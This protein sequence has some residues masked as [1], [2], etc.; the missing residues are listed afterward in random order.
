MGT[1]RAIGR[2]L[3][4]T[5]TSAPRSTERRCSDSRSF[6]AEILTRIMAKIR[7]YLTIF[8]KFGRLHRVLPSPPCDW[9]GR[10]VFQ[11]AARY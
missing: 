8:G 3:S 6:N 4:V 7:P 1:I 2:S 5:T 9:E 10:R 11:S